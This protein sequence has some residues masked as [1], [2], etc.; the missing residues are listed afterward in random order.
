[1]YIS[2]LHSL[3]VFVGCRLNKVNNETA[4]DYRI[5]AGRSAGWDWVGVQDPPLGLGGPVCAGRA[6]GEG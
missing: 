5:I 4:V 1:M 2:F 3:N 6:E